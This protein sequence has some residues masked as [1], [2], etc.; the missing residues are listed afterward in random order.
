M[1]K[2]SVLTSLY[3]CS[4][5]LETFLRHA[6][7]IEGAET[8]EFLL[9]HNDPLE[10]EVACIRK[11]GDKI[12]NLRHIVIKERES[13]YSSWN[14]GIKLS[15]GE[16]ITIWNVDDIRFSDSIINQANLLEAHRNAA[17]AYGDVYISGN[18]GSYGSEVYKHPEW[19]NN[20]KE[21][22]RSYIMSCF[23]MWRASIHQEIGYYD[24][25]FLCVGDFDFQIRVA[26]KYPFVKVK[27]PLGV[28]LV[29]GSHN[30]SN[31]P[32]QVI[33]NNMIYFRYGV[34]EKIQLHLLRRA[35]SRYKKNERLFF[36]KWGTLSIKSPF[37]KNQ[38]IRGMIVC[39][40]KTPFFLLRSLRNSTRTGRYYIGNAS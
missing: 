19:E 1:I 15:L 18:Y 3:R 21:F 5:F 20:E 13:L 38:R 10:E 24:E 25:Q 40:L 9:L 23:Q 35:V 2:I 17:V 7:C 4:R 14:R 32:R 29:G 34:Y 12:P 16:F 27:K 36:G 33:E 37:N 31:T 30:I 28:F 26:M 8:I 39:V 6:S 11:F 22:C